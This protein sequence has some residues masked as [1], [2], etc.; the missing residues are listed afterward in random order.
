[1]LSEEAATAKA[2]GEADQLRSADIVGSLGSGFEDPLAQMRAF[3]DEV[4]RL[5][6]LD[7]LSEQE[8]AAAKAQAN[9]AYQDQ[10]LANADSFF[11]TLAEL[12]NSSNKELA[13]LGKA[14]AIAQAT[15]DGYVAVQKALASAPPPF[16]YALAAA[17]G[18]VA[19]ANVA[20]I[21]G[22]ADGGLV[23]GQ[24][25]PRQDNQI[26]AL[27]VGEYVVN[28]KATAENRALLDAINTGRSVRMPA[29]P[30]PATLGSRS[31][32]QSISLSMPVDARGADMGAAL[33]I[34]RT[35]ADLERRLPG[36]IKGVTTR[37]EYYRLGR[38]AA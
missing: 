32:N 29:L 19:A 7:L 26:R 22:M 31:G 15:I 13:A 24:G 2:T 18:V 4:D 10:R 23:R 35:V 12:Q 5:R 6:Q 1:G 25:G 38:N 8:A 9:A 28:A 20:Q 36:I 11:S 34:E 3:Y 37:R 33:H 17:V 27:S 30:D 16:N 21:A 14:A